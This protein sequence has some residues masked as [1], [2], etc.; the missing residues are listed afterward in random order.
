MNAPEI[1]KIITQLEK[2][3]AATR[4]FPRQMA[5]HDKIKA[6]KAELAALKK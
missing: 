5:I 2:Q 4:S 3:R 6:L 1:E